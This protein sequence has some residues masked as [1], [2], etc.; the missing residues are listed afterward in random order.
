MI[1]SK[2]QIL[3]GSFYLENKMLG[4]INVNVPVIV[5]RKW[6]NRLALQSKNLELH[7]KI[8]KLL[9]MISG[10]A[11]TLS[12]MLLIMLMPECMLIIDVSGIKN[13]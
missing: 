10:T 2:C 13:L 9:M 11:Y 1:I 7:L 6:I 12:L 8:K 3:T 5:G 4:K